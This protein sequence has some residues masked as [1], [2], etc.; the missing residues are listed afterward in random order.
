MA[1]IVIALVCIPAAGFK[2]RIPP[3]KF[4]QM[5]FKPLFNDKPYLLFCTAEFFGFMGVYIVFFYMQLYALTRCKTGNTTASLLLPII[6]A[7]S[8]VG[9]LIPNYLS[10]KYTGPMNMQIPF[11]FSVAILAFGWIAVKSTAGVLVFSILYGF[12]S[13]AFVSLGGPICFSVTSDPSTVGTRLGF[14]TAVC[15]I[16]LLIGNPIAG[17][18]WNNGDWLG[19]QIWTALL[20]LVSAF[21]QLAA[22]IA[23]VG[24][25]VELRT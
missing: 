13:G 11:A 5:E 10:D 25:A 20:L 6:N 14:L 16:G 2:Q 12:T 15:G 23:K 19:L 3:T 9:R 4:H 18:I 1:F 22:R 17:A 24:W 8:L 7:G 21:F